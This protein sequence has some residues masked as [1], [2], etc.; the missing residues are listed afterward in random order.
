VPARRTYQPVPGG[1]T[2]GMV[3]FTAASK[4]DAQGLI[5]GDPIVFAE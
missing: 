1:G 3:I 5:D 4:E 2:V